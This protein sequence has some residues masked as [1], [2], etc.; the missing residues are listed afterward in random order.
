[1]MRRPPRSTRVRSSAASDVYKRQ[2]LHGETPQISS[3]PDGDATPHTPYNL[4]VP[5]SACP[6]CNH[7]ISAWENIPVISYVLL[8]GKCRGCGAAISPRYPIIEAISGI[9]VSYTHLTLP[10]ILRV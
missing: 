1:M 7:A 8:R 9:P 6:H 3:H 10:T 2:E 4:V 5:R